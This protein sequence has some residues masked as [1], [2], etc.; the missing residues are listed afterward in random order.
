MTTLVKT[1]NKTPKV[2]AAGEGDRFQML[3]HTMTLKVSNR[4]T[5]GQ[6]VMY[7]ATDT[8][9]NGAPLHTHPWEETFYI[10]DGELEVRLGNRTVLAQTGTSIYF[11][12]N[13]AHNF[14]IVSPTVR[15]LVILPGSADAFY[16]EVGQKITALPP[17][18]DTFQAICAKYNVGLMPQATA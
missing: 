10:L 15:L 11:P 17:D 7:E 5:Q 2:L 14:R 16:R 9:N 1:A 4:D 3:S 12:E 18:P 13:I 8:V 6:W